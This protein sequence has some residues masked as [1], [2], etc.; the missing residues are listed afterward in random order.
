MEKKST[1]N[2]EEC[3]LL[4]FIQTLAMFC[5]LDAINSLKL[6]LQ[7]AGSEADGGDNSPL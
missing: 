7:G 4:P 3:M 2:E 5:N 1:E 6:G